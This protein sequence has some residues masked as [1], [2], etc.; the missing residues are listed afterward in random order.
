MDDGRV[1]GVASL[2]ADISGHVQAQAELAQHRNHLEEL[3][4][5]RTTELADVNKEL[6]S[7]SYSVSHDL[8]APLRAIDGFSQAL[9]EDYAD[10][11]DDTGKDYLRRTRKASQR[12]A[13]LIDD[14]LLLSR[15]ARQE[16]RLE[17][18]DLSTSARDI[19]ESLEGGQRKSKMNYIIQDHLT[20]EGDPRLLKIAL[21]N[22]LS[23][24][25]KF[26]ANKAKPRVEFGMNNHGDER[27]YYVRDNGVGFHMQHAEKLFG[28]FQRLHKADEFPGTGIG[29]ATVAR[30]IHRHGGR[31]WAESAV[32]RGA[33]FYFTLGQ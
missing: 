17:T 5:E 26:T 30:I 2:V 16:I 8:R 21:V 11:V 6:E 23:N 9:L 18:M 20:A 32:N 33:T 12:M 24:A 14:L 4:A 3:V 22:L 27:I 25:V 1:I 19:C 15:V 29:L 28:P 7:F 31:V 10:A 13:E